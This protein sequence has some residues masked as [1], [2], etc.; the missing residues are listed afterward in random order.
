[1][2]PNVPYISRRAARRMWLG[3]SGALA[4]LAFMLVSCAS[5]AETDPWQEFRNRELA[6]IEQFGEPDTFY[7]VYEGSFGPAKIRLATWMQSPGMFRIDNDMGI[8]SV[9]MGFDGKNAWLQTKGGKPRPLSK[10]E[11]EE[12]YSSMYFDSVEFLTDEGLKAE[13]AGHENW[14]G[15][16]VWLVK[17]ESP[18]GYRRDLFIRDGDFELAGYRTYGTGVALIKVYDVTRNGAMAVP[19]KVEMELASLSLKLEFKLVE[20]REGDEIDPKIF[21]SPQGKYLPLTLAAGDSYEIPLRPNPAGMLILDA[22]LGGKTGRFLLD[23][24]ASSS[25]L[26]STFVEG[27]KIVEE[28]AFSAVGVGGAQDAKLVRLESGLS[29]GPDCGA[30]LPAEITYMAMD[31]SALAP[32]LGETLSGIIGEDLMTR[33]VVTI[34]GGAGKITLAPYS[35]RQLGSEPSIWDA[36]GETEGDSKPSEGVF[37]IHEVGGLILVD[38]LIPGG[39]EERFIV[40]TGFKG[41]IGLF[42]GAAERLGLEVKKSRGGSFIGGIGGV[43]AMKGFV[44]AFTAEFFGEASDFENCPIISGPIESVVGGSA[45]GII[46]IEFFAGKTVVLDYAARRIR[47]N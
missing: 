6:N 39:G 11:E 28:S 2:N 10:A 7:S 19:G 32:G 38:A 26:D 33:A 29:L 21:L 13:N 30:T 24:G 15:E 44:P 25:I 17:L 35:E 12:L 45:A 22:S 4:L 16:K 1:M 3:V 41:T 34:D 20:A 9:S 18:E 43:T 40:D 27:L 5:S 47:V 8:I 46:G 37:P 36:F 31:L 14:N 42:E 23:T